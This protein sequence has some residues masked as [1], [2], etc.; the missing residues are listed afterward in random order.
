[1]WADHLIVWSF[2]ELSFLLIKW[3]SIFQIATSS[4]LELERKMTLNR[5]LSQ[6]VMNIN[7]E[8][9]EPF[10]VLGKCWG[11]LLQQHNLAYPAWDNRSVLS[12]FMEVALS[13]LLLGVQVHF[14]KYCFMASSWV[15]LYTR[16]SNNV[17]WR[18]FI[19]FWRV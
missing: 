19:L 10:S 17:S 8:W 5:F 13:I 2:P 4:S 15:L 9:E 11:C 16:C 14:E 3:F 18:K 6:L 7:W 12:S 1:M